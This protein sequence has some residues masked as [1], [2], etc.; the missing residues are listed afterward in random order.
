MTSEAAWIKLRGLRLRYF[1]FHSFF[2]C[3]PI[4]DLE[5]GRHVASL[6]SLRFSSFQT[7]KKY[8]FEHFFAFV[9]LH[10][11]R[12]KC[13]SADRL[14]I[15]LGCYEKNVLESMFGS[16]DLSADSFESIQ[17]EGFFLILVC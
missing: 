12:G 11:S 14:S 17:N 4:V 3:I 16:L 6:T 15:G 7:K 10:S 2:G 13:S 9:F 5:Q 1:L 8:N